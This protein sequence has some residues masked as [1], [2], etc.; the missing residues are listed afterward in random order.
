MTGSS[1]QQGCT[2][3][4]KFQSFRMHL[5]FQTPFKPFSRGQGRG[6]SGVYYQGR[7]E[8][9]VLDS[10]GLEGK[11]NETGGIYSIKAPDLNM[12][13]P[14]LSWQTYD[15]EFIAAKFDTEGKKQ[16]HAT[17]T[18]KLNGVVVQKDVK[19]THKTTAAPLK[20]GPEPGPIYIQNHSN[21]VKFRNIWVLPLD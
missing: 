2:S 15:V 12:C 5:E 8:T 9:Q 11:V 7:Y 16:E 17:L 10:F 14:P 18:V 13:L 3:K 1:L 20:E 19:L 6:N 21:P 4:D